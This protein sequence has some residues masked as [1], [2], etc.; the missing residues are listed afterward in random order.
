[1]HRLFVLEHPDDLWP[2][3]LRP[4]HHQEHRTRRGRICWIVASI[5]DELT[6]LEDGLE[7]VYRE[8][9]RRGF[10][11]AVFHERPATG[12]KAKPSAIDRLA[13]TSTFSRRRMQAY[14]GS[15]I[16]STARPAT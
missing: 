7:R 1:M 5:E 2:R 10:H 16:A 3:M 14:A 6:V 11:A 9:H 4:R 15:I 8:I 12:H 13:A